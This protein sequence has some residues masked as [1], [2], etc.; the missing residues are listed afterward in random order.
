M[1]AEEMPTFPPHLD[2]ALVS[3]VELDEQTDRDF[4]H[5]TES[6]GRVGNNRLSHVVT[7]KD[8]GGKVFHARSFDQEERKAAERYQAET[9]QTIQRNRQQ[10]LF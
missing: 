10:N 3:V 6:V 9:W 7:V 1:F 8:K 2:P 4:V 5:P